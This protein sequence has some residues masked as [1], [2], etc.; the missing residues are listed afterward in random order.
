MSE[1]QETAA[2]P[3]IQ[4][5]LLRARPAEAQVLMDWAR[6]LS[7]IRLGE[8]RGRKKVAAQLAL[9][10]DTKAAWPLVKVMARALKIIAWD[11][12]SWKLRLGL[13]A[14]VATFVVV[15]NAGAGIVALGGGLGL[16][17]WVL[18]G[19]GGVLVGLLADLV[20]KRMRKP[21]ADYPKIHR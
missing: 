16:P 1:E 6:G 17:L 20:R 2:V 14:I 19:G 7:A 4:Q 12:R 8:L 3:A 13:G 21:R 11:A 9:I 10:R 15:G 18:M 5:A